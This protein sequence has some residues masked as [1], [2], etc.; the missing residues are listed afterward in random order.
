MSERPLLLAIDTSTEQ[1][2]V[3]L[4]DGTCLD[5]VSW[6]SCRE[7]TVLLLDEI[8]HQLK[9][10]KVTV[11]DLGAI[12]VA[13]GPGRFNA[14]RVG[15]SIGKG[16]AMSMD[17]PIIGISTLAAIVHPYR[18]REHPVV[19]VIEAGRERL[20]WQIF[21]LDAAQHRADAR[22]TSVD[23]FLSS[24]AELVAEV[25][26]TGEVN[27]TL[28]QRL[29]GV[30]GVFVPPHAGRLGRAGAVA[31]LAYGRLID[32]DHDDIV[33]LEPVYLHG[34]KRDALRIP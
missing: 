6:S 25:C 10:S 32:G 11:G 16:L 21:D 12:A 2:G 22:N 28:A 5:D 34:P 14:L 19:G 8:D 3:A 1:T 15:M 27:P 31:E 33:Q 7:Q 17:I 20:V 29:D 24:I 9:R 13:T 26:V 30:A 18:H 4:Y 23:E